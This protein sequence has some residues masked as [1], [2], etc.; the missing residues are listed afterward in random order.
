MGEDEDYKQ[1]TK[2]EAIEDSKEEDVD[3]SKEHAMRNCLPSLLQQKR[4]LEKQLVRHA[5][6]VGHAKDSH[7][8][9][10]ED[11]RE[12]TVREETSKEHDVN[13]QS[14]TLTSQRDQPELAVHKHEE[15]VDGSDDEK[16]QAEHMELQKQ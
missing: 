15:D 2:S 8:E 5:K 10:Q 13:I 6:A 12:S 11:G 16:V 9:Y 3:D 14:G 4:T 1:M 7:G